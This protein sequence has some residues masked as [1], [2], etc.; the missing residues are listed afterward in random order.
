MKFIKSILLTVAVVLTFGACQSPDKEFEHTN[1]IIGNMLMALNANA[2]KTGSGI[3]G[4]IR[5]YNAAGE[6][7]PASEVTVESVAG[8]HGEIL[9][10]LDL[11]LKGEYDPEHCYLG[12]SLT[13][14][15]IIKPG[16]GGIKNI[17]NRDPE[18]GIARGLDFE[19]CPGVGTPRPYKVIGYFEGEYEITPAN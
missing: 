7:V 1:N 2:I 12:A 3:K 4:V 8:G 16:L 19:C 15:Q 13:F 6:L 14:D 11:D 18:T 9:F 5:E 10:V 17:T